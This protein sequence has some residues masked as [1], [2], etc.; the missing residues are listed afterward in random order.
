MEQGGGRIADGQ[1]GTSEMLGPEIE[2]S[3]RAG[4][5]DRCR[6]GRCAR[7]AQ[8]ADSLVVGG[9][10]GGGDAA[11]D[12][13]RVA[14]NGR[15]GLKRLAGRRNE[16]GAKDEMPGGLDHA[17]GMD[18]AH[19][20]LGLV[21]GK[22]GQIGLAADDGEGL[23]VNGVA[24]LDVVVLRHRPSRQARAGTSPASSTIS[25]GVSPARPRKRRPIPSARPTSVISA[26]RGW[27]QPLA[28]PETWRCFPT[29]TCGAS[30]APSRRAAIWPEAQPSLP[31]QALARRRGSVGSVMKP[32]PVAAA[33]RPAGASSRS[34]LW[35]GARRNVVSL[36]AAARSARAMRALPWIWAKGRAMGAV[37]PLRISSVWP[38][39]PVPP[40]K[41]EGVGPAFGA[42][43][44]PI[45]DAAPPPLRG[46]L[47]GGNGIRCAGNKSA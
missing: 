34:R 43:S 33:M 47:G 1:D 15:A 17:G 39:H 8:G 30:A 32:R 27:A 45:L 4:I 16:T 12:H 14:E 37:R 19:G 18:H 2:R 10:A 3:G 29:G 31:T 7:I 46:R 21:F 28:Q 9:K 6:Q 41:G 23:P 25:S 44:S 5:A 42:K 22:A 24:I 35:L 26:G 36:A 38:P 20:K 11:R 40:R 13:F